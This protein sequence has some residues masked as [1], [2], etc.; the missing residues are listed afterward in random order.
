MTPFNWYSTNSSDPNTQFLNNNATSL[1]TTNLITAFNF[2]YF[3]SSASLLGS[4]TTAGLSIQ[5]LFKH[6][7]ILV[8]N[9]LAQNTQIPQFTKSQLIFQ[10]DLIAIRMKFL[11]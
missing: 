6:R 4:P 7:N 3:I 11:I 10:P 5:I 1:A 8:S 9:G 2:I